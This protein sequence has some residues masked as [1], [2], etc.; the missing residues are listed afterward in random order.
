MKI[1][2]HQSL[3]GYLNGHQLLA[4]SK[5]LSIYAKKTLLFQSDLTGSMV[6]SGYDSYITG[7]P[8][9][10]SNIYVFA[11]TW[12]ASEMSRPGCVWTHSLLIDFADIGKIPE[13]DCLYAI[14]KRP[15]VNQYMRFS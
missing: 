12:Y 5:E 6:E 13:L 14:F 9:R 15:E 4:C 10:D 7:Y 8:L 1:E 11:K 3:H 2:L